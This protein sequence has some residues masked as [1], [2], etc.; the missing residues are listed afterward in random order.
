MMRISIS[1]ALGIVMAGIVATG[2]SAQAT[3]A[4]VKQKG[5]DLRLEPGRPWLRRAGCPGQLVRSR[6]RPLPRHRGRH[7][8]R[9][10]QGAVRPALGQGP[11]H[12]TQVRPG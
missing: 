4:S 11:L 3:L 2:A 9:P 12:G 1:V 8:R 10:D 6:R 5:P 7:L